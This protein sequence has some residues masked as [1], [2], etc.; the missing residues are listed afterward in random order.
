[1]A[2]ATQLAIGQSVGVTAWAEQ[3]PE[4]L[5]Q[6]LMQ[7]ATDA[8]API[9]KLTVE[10]VLTLRWPDRSPQHWIER[11][12]A[13]AAAA[14]N[15][16]AALLPNGGANLPSFLTIGVAN[17]KQSLFA[18]CG[19]TLVTTHDA[20]RIIVLRTVYGG[21]FDALKPFSLWH[22]AYQ[23]FITQ[24]PLHVLPGFNEQQ[25]R[26][27]ELFALGLIFGYITADGQWY[28]YR[29][30][31]TLRTAVRLAQGRRNAITAFAAQRPLQLEVLVRVEAQVAAEGASRT[32]QRIEQ[33]VN[34]P[35]TG[36]DPTLNRL[37]MAARAYLSQLRPPAQ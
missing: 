24:R 19:H 30:A 13:L 35:A 28:S 5:A 26:S 9:L 36:N 14:W 16:D 17:A 31:D 15:P 29:P 3:T 21:A 22:Y 7:S 32:A 6:H 37:R 33:W 2:A 27:E 10:D 25:D 34:Q 23:Q 1:V 20:E 8:F 4:Q 12:Q 11:L 18:E